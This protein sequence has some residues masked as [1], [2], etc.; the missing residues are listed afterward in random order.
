M[1]TCGWWPSKN[2]RKTLGL[3]NFRVRIT[4]VPVKQ[5]APNKPL[6]GRRAAV[7]YFSGKRYYRFDA[8]IQLLKAKRADEKPKDK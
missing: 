1:Q 7:K 3:R 5:T 6:T 4:A 2:G 8:E